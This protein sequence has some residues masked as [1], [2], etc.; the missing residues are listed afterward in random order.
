MATARVIFGKQCQPRSV[1]LHTLR[2]H[3]SSRPRFYACN[4]KKNYCQNNVSGAVPQPSTAPPLSARSVDFWNSKSTWKRAAINTTRCLIGC[5]IGDFSAMW[6]FQ[7]L[8]PELGM[9]AIM[10]ISM[11]SGITTSMTLETVLLR[12]GRDRLS[13]RTAASTAAGM[14][15]ISMLTMELAQNMVDYYLT[16]GVVAFSSPAFWGAAAVSLTVGFL[17]PLPYNYLRLRK[18]GK[19]CH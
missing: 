1:L 15:L 7:A 18:Y 17:S 5:S 3:Q 16:G 13:W 10:A 9:S 4:A 2:L 14:S 11:A 12:Y 8:Y 19:A 6:S